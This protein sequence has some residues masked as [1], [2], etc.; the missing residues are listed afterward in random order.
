ML[1]ALLLPFASQ[2]QTLTVCDGTVNNQYIPFD[3]Y[4]ADAAQHNQMIYPASELT[5]MS[6]QAIMQ[7]VFYIDP[8]ASNGG[9]T[10]ASRLGTWTVSLG[11]TTATT[12]SALDNT[13]TL[14]QVYQGYFDCSTGT[15]TIEFDQ[16]YL[17]N[18]GNLLVD[19]NHAAASWNRWYFLGVTT[20]DDVAYNSNDGDSYSF[21]P[22]CT[23]TY[24]AAPTCFKVSDLAIDATQTTNS[25]LTLTWADA[26][27]TGATYSVYAATPTDTTLVAA[28]INGTTYTVTSLNANT[29]YTFV[30]MTDCGGGDVT[31][32]SL[33]VSGRTACDATTAIPFIENFGGYGTVPTSPASGPAILPACWFYAS[34]GTNTAE[35][36]SSSYYGGLIQY[37]YTSSYG[38]LVANDPYLCLP[39]QVTGSAV[40]S[41]TYIGY[42]TARGNTKYAVMP[43]FAEELS[44]LQIS[45]DYKMSTAYSATGAATTLELGYVTGDD[46]STFV[47]MVSYQAVSSIQS[48]EELSLSTL[49]ANAPAGARLAF[50]FSG[51]HNGTGTYSYSTVYCGIDNIAVEELPNCFHVTN[52]AVSATS[53]SSI[54]LTWADDV[55]SSATYTVSDAEGVIASGITGTTYTVE[56]LDAN[57]EYTF[58][59]VANCSATDASEAEMISGRTACI[60]MTID[61]NNLFSES[62]EGTA[63][64]PDCWSTAHTDI[65]SGRTD[66]WQRQTTAADVHTG[67]ASAKLPDMQAG[68]KANLVTPL[69]DIDEANAYMISFWMRRVSSTKPNEG[70]KVW[71][72]TTPDTIGGTPLMHIRRGFAMG[73]ITETEAG[74]YKYSAVI[75]TSGEVYIIFEGISEYGNYSSIDDIAIEVAPSCLAV[76]NLAVDNVTSESVTLSWVDANN[77]GATYS[78][79]TVTPDD[80]TLVEDNITGTTY[81]VENL[82]A[83]TPY[84]FGVAADCGGDLTEMVVVNART[85]CT[86]IVIDSENPYTENFDSYN[87]T[88]SSSSAPSGYPNHEQPGCWSFLNMSTSSSTYPQAFM[89]GYS[90]Y[91]VS[92]NCLFFKSSN[93]TPL[94]AIL[95]DFEATTALQL[96]FSYRNEGVSAYN[97]TILVGVMSDASDATTFVA[98]DSCA[99]TTTITPVEVNIPAGTLD[100]GARLAFCYRGGTSQNYYAAIDNVIVRE[101]PACLHVENL[102]VSDITAH[103]ATLTWEGDADGY[104]IYDMSDTTVYEYATDTTVVLDALN[105]E[106]AYTFGV[107]SNCGSD[108]S[109]F[110]TISFTTLISCPAPTGLAASLTPGDGTVATLNWH[111]AGE[112]SEWQ[113]CLNGDMAN[114]ITVS[115][116]THD[117]TNLTAEQAITAKVRAICG[118]GDT[119]AWSTEITFT[120]TNAYMITVNDGTSTNNYVPIYGTY[121]DEGIKS[122]FI[123]PANDLNAMQYG[124]INSL[125]FYSSNANVNWGAAS[126]A[127]YMTETSE[128]TVNSL[129]PVSNMTQV[130]TGSLSIVNNVME[131]TLTTPYQYMGGNLLIAFEQPT[132]GTW[133]SC[134]WYGVSATGASQGGYGSSVSQRNFL[135]KTTFAYTPGEAPSCPTVSNL[136]ASNVTADEATLSWTGDASSYNLYVV[137]NSDTTLVQNLSDTTITLTGLTAMTNYIYGVSAVCTNDES[138]KRFVNFTTACAAVTLPYTE[139]FTATSATRNCWTL[140]SNN[141]A[142]V[143][144][145]NGMGFV[146]VSGRDV[147]R[148]SS[149]T[150]ASDYNQYGFSPLMNVSTDATNL[151]VKVVYGTYGAS[152]QLFF[153]YITATDTVWDPTPYTTNGGYSASDWQSQTFVIPAT[154]TQL[155]VHYYGN[156]QYYAWVDSVVVTELTGDYCYPVSALTVDSATTT[157]ISLSW[158]SDAT[159]F[160]VLDMADSSVIAANVTTTSYEVTGLTV[161]TAYTFGVVVNCATGNSDTMTITANTACATTAINLPFNEDFSAT[162]S[163]RNCWTLIDADND[164]LGWT[165]Q[166]D[167][168]GDAQ[169]YMMS[170]SYDNATY[171]ALTPDNW[172]ISPKLHSNA[173]STVTMQWK[174]ASATSYPAEHYGIY[175]STTTTDTSAFTMVNEWTISN[176]SE[177]VKT[178]DLSAYAGQDIYVA[179]RHHNCT[180]MYVLMIDDVQVYEG[181]YVPDTLKVTFATADATMGT[182]DP[183]PGVYNYIEGDTIFFGSQANNGYIFQK[184]VIVQGNNAP[185]ELGPQYANGYYVPASSWMSYDSVSFTAYFEP[186]VPDSVQVTYAV[187]NATMGTITPAAGTYNVVVG[188]AVTAQATPNTGYELTAWVLGIYNA[189]GSLINADTLL[190]TDAEFSNPVNYGTIPQSFADNNYTITVTAL[191]DVQSTPQPVTEATIAASDIVYWVG[192]GNNQMVMAVNWAN[193]AYAWGV[194]F[195][196]SITVQNALDTIAAYDPRFNWTTGSYGLDDITFVEGNINLAG[197]TNSY[198]ESKNNGV[199]DAGLAQTLANGDFEKWAQ[200]VAGVVTDSVDYGGVYYPIYTYPMT[201]TPMWAP[202]VTP[203]NLTVTYATNDA[204]LGTTNPAPG[205]YTYG[206]SDT[207]FFNAIPTTGNSFVAWIIDY[208]D[209]TADTVGAQYQ[210]GYYFLASTMMGYGI[211]SMTF[212][213]YFQA[214][215]AT[216]DSVAVTYTVND[217]TMGSINPNGVVMTA[218]GDTLAAVATANA[219][220]ELYAWIVTTYLGGQVANSDTIETDQTAA[221]FGT[222]PQVYADYGATLTITA[223]FRQHEGINDVTADMNIYST[224][225]KIIVKGAEGENIYIYDLNGRTVATKANAN[226]TMEFTMANSGVYMVKVGNAPAKRVLVIR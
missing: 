205:T 100:N 3:G 51:T 69:F 117:L 134:T 115:D 119:S 155:A 101:A 56:N 22:K 24:G 183:A 105:S 74:W 104:T 199:I 46:T 81:T 127:V 19:L 58:N 57:T 125:T 142:N 139:T 166:I 87:V 213:A 60:A 165:N 99:Q 215:V 61:A 154:A 15:L 48:V 36:A 84:V 27:N 108:E 197:D 194:R 113:I 79:Y 72:N 196:G 66:V 149:Y 141:T 221:I 156:Y 207:V 28:N 123:I 114:L 208:S 26:L 130:Y 75:P 110:V 98:L 67:S 35:T 62:F 78:V 133:S 226:E 50:K 122:Q 65:A 17:Y 86:T 41:Q 1:V 82:T 25:S 11:E 89:T 181:A 128:T 39:I 145:S 185:Q 95:P 189:T 38:C 124:T 7:M 9:N 96:Q 162:S 216:P 54:T 18:G 63:F 150:S 186:G 138:D 23:F 34:N 131:F 2:A 220:F 47:S 135:P 173:N 118:A 157:S 44:T 182:T 188:S 14:T 111:E 209:G 218:V 190:A 222:M 225:N 120:P 21:L 88:I 212:T 71:V 219:G 146:T 153:G 172:M 160:T 32:Y 103:T 217:A 151:Q 85:A 184:W 13:T 16:A 59:V 126:F 83:N 187:N 203:T 116:S 6:G 163:T 168:T 169:E 20:T 214:G 76:T 73:E 211:T 178:L 158:T 136:T 132:T 192:S 193:A 45:F 77:T 112:A 70:V 109:E 171:E 107:T 42:E 152:D 30:V 5:D 40:T 170:Y 80:T 164:G 29:I 93:T 140:V 4:N 92:G 144:G 143:G 224:D 176:G 52:L 210:S 159:S 175:V 200:P 167:Y 191:F 91:A 33:P 55:N 31:G 97:G 202:Q 148:F 195:N 8:S 64:P 137:S 106:T 129:A 201:I 49:A 147:M 53:S 10:A 223:M 37:G 161:M 12:L 94:Y 68:N 102:V 206:A 90:S 43:A 204:N 121:V 198:W 174:V 179:F 177:E 180:D